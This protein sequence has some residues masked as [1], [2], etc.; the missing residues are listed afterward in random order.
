MTCSLFAIHDCILMIIVILFAIVSSIRVLVV[1][2]VVVPTIV[3]LVVLVVVI[4]TIVLSLLLFFFF[5]F[6]GGGGGGVGTVD[7]VYGFYEVL[8]SWAGGKGG[9]WRLCRSPVGK[10]GVRTPTLHPE[11]RS[12]KPSKPETLNPKPFQVFVV[13]GSRVRAGTSQGAEGPPLRPL[14]L[15]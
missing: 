15:A 7:G 8:G 9:S 13:L 12:P 14:E 1:L 2:L 6:G 11:A 4:L 3:T 5:F 10:R